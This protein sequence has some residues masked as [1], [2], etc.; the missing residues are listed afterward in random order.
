MNEPWKTVAKIYL[1]Q[2]KFI[3]KYVARSV[4]KLIKY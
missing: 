1:S 4:N 3:K 2:V